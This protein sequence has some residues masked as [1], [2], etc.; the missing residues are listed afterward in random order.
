MNFLSAG[1]TI[2]NAMKNLREYGS[3]KKGAVQLAS[4][5]LTAINGI[6]GATI[7]ILMSM[8]VLHAIPLAGTIV[9]I[10]LMVGAVSLL[11]YASTI[12]AKYEPE[13]PRS[14]EDHA[15]VTFAMRKGYL[16]S[17]F[18]FGFPGNSNEFDCPE[19]GGSATQKAYC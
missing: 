10:I 13:H 4:G 14:G 17:K 3:G 15:S 16:H 8:Q 2:W 7:G 11:L 5:I 12:Q 19:T 1:L 18:I 9:S 6:M